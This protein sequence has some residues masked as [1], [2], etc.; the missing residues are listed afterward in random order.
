MA[1]SSQ[2][3]KTCQVTDA[4]VP[5]GDQGCISLTGQKFPVLAPQAIDDPC[6]TIC[7]YQEE[8]GSIISAASLQVAVDCCYL[9]SSPV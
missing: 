2:G 3:P 4:A 5:V 6:N 1:L 8:F 7:L 9:I